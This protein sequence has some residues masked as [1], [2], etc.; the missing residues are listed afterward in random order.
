MRPTVSK[1]IQAA[2]G[3]EAFDLRNILA[4]NA[5]GDVTGAARTLNFFGGPDTVVKQLKAYHDQCGMGVVDLFFQQPRVSHAE[6]MK[7]IELFGKEV[8][9]QLK[10]F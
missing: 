4:G 7:E 1:A 9:P 6:V 2:R 5:Q 10:E 8:L 3:G